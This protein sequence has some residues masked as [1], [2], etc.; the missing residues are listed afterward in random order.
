[1][2]VFIVCLLIPLSTNFTDILIVLQAFVHFFDEKPFLSRLLNDFW[3]SFPEIKSAVPSPKSDAFPA[4]FS[5]ML[6][7]ALT[8]VKRLLARM[9]KKY[10]LALPDGQTLESMVWMD[11]VEEVEESAEDA[12]GTK[13]AI[14]QSDSESLQSSESETETDTDADEKPKVEVPNNA[15]DDDEATT[16]DTDDVVSAISNVCLPCTHTH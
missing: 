11:I 7:T 12:G 9:I 6:K 5:R 4:I 2:P 14:E 3:L 1:M 13:S 8:T 10:G 16:A 15:D